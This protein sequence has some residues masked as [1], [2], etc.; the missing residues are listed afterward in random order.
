MTALFQEAK[1]FI[2]YFDLKKINVNLPFPIYTGAKEDNEIYLIISGV[3]MIKA[4]AAVGAFFS[5]IKFEQKAFYE[6]CD[7]VNIGSCGSVNES[8]IGNIFRIN[9]ILNKDSGKSFYPD[10]LMVSELK[11]AVIE[12]GSRIYQ[13]NIAGCELLFDMEAASIYEAGNLFVG[14]DRMHFLK[15]VSDAGN[16]NIDATFLENVMDKNKETISCFIE[17]LIEF[18]KSQKETIFDD[19]KYTEYMDLFEKIALQLHASVTMKAK[20]KQ[21]MNYAFLAGI[22]VKTKYETFEERG[23][24]PCRDKKAGK[25]VLDELQN[26]ICGTGI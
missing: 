13:K 18:R 8:D 19:N 3:G 21:L 22:D 7:I 11:E 5:W 26:F 20:I 10:L 15:V 9:K 1:P 4:S 2:K 25:K 24:V 17:N 23:V 6:D 12:S 14:P 16:S